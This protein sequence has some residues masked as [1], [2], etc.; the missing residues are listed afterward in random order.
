MQF[1]F[2]KVHWEKFSL[3]LFPSSKSDDSGNSILK[4]FKTLKLKVCSL[5]TYLTLVN[6]LIPFK[7]KKQKKS[8]LP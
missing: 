2:R 7:R 4:N 5:K 1:N 3:N 6:K 8:Q